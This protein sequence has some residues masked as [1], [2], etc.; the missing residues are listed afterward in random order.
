MCL[1]SSVTDDLLASYRAAL[2]NLKSERVALMR[3]RDLI[4]VRIGVIDRAVETLAAVT[5]DEEPF[6]GS[7]ADAIRAV[8]KAKRASYIPTDL[9]NRVKDVGYVFREGSN[10]MAAVHGVLKRLV[11]NGTVKTKEIA[12][13][14]GVTRYFWHEFA[15]DLVKP[16]IPAPPRPPNPVKTVPN[17]SSASLDTP[18][19]GEILGLLSAKKSGEKP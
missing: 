16:A 17:F 6:D 10:E 1:N 11:E 15:N 18:S 13:D 3:Q 9:R 2:T 7:L 19:I 4:D 12:R 8:L 14:P 5:G